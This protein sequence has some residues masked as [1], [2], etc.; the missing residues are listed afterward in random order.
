MSLLRATLTLLAG[1]ALAQLIPLLLGPLI[2]RLFTPEAFGLFTS[3][4]TIAAT[5]AVVACARYEFALPMA[6]DG[7]EA[8]ALLALCLRIGLIVLLLCLPL[9]WA[10]HALG[11]L[12]LPQLLPL[13]VLAAGLLQLLMLWS[14]RAHRFRALAVARVLQYGGTPCCRWPSAMHCGCNTARRSGR[15]RPGRCWRH[16]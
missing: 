2:T 15:I 8:R 5:V 12:P 13:A 4:S 7:R 6:R 1:G 14:N 10:L 11:Y 3:F 16:R 9:A